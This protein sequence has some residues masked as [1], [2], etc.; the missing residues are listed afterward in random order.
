MSIDH[1]LSS[2][3]LGISP[4]EDTS[5]VPAF[6]LAAD[7]H[8]QGNQGD[9]WF[10]PTTWGTRAANGLKFASAA[11][12]SGGAQLF[13]AGV[14]LGNM[15]G[16][17]DASEVNTS[18]LMHSIDDDIGVYYDKNR[19]AEDLV[20]FIAS[21]FVPGT[22]GMKVL[23]AGQKVLE[24]AIATGRIGGN[25]AKAT[26]LLV[27]KTSNFIS[28]AAQDINAAQATFSLINANT[29][30]ALAAGAGQ[31]ALEAA[32]FE[33]AVQATMFSSPIL[34]DQD[35]WDIVKNIAVGG[36]AGGVIGGVLEGAG[37]LSKI[38]KQVKEF[39]FANKANSSRALAQEMNRSDIDLVR[40]AQDLDNATF[41]N[42][43]PEALTPE[44]ELS[45][46]VVNKANFADKQR[47][48]LNDSRQ[49]IHNITSSDDGLIGNMVADA[50][51]GMNA[52]DTAA[53]FLHTKHISRPN[54]ITPIERLQTE[55]NKAVHEGSEEAKVELT[56]IQTSYVKLTGE[57]A[58]AVTDAKPAI[59]SI[60]DTVPM[61]GF[62]SL[63]EAVQDEVRGYKFKL[64]SFWDAAAK[65]NKGAHTEAEARYIWA[66]SVKLPEESM[67]IH[68]NDIPLLER[69]WQEG[70]LDLKL[71]NN[72]GKIVQDGFTSREDLLAKIIE[73][74]ENVASDLVLKRVFRNP[75]A[76]GGET[77]TEAIAKI[78]NTKRG[79]LD[80][81]VV[82]NPLDDYFSHQ[83]AT[84]NY[85][86]AQAKKG[87]KVND[88]FDSLY[89]PS[90]AKFNKHLPYDM[91]N[92]HVI[93]GMTWIKNQEARFQEDVNKVFAARVPSEL[94]SSVGHIPEDAL[95]R[96]NKKGSGA[97]IFTFANGNYGSL[98]SIMQSI[99]SVTQKL[100]Q[101][102]RKDTSD[103]FQG[104]LTNLGKNQEAVIEFNSMN[105]K[106]TRS[107][108]LWVRIEDPSGVPHMIT[109][110]G[111]IAIEKAQQEGKDI[112]SIW[113]S[114]R[115]ADN[116]IEFQN[117]EVAEVVDKMINRSAYR[118]TSFQEI[119]AAQGLTDAK[120]PTVYRPVR[121]N[122]QDYKHFAFVVDPKVTSQ[123]HVTMIF[124]SDADK[125]AKLRAAAERE[126]FTVHYKSEVEE[127]KKARQE[128]EYA[129][130]LNESYI[131]STLA[132]RGVFSE[133]FVKTD[134]QQTINGIL[135]QHFREDD[136]LAMELM[137]MK[138][139]KAFD[140]LEDQ[141]R[142]YSRVEASTL[143]GPSLS[144]IENS[145]KNPYVDY[146]KT[147][148]DI[149]RAP[150]YS[151]WY[152]FNKMIDSQVSRAVNTIREAWAG[153]KSP[154]EL[155]Q[156]NKHLDTYGMNTGFRDAALEALV[157]HPAPKG[158]L[159][160]FIRGANA[161][162]AR[163]TLGLDPMNA[164]NNAIGANVLRGTELTQITRAI[165]NGDSEIA[166]KLAELS[167]ITL[168][169]VGDQITA[170]SK[171]LGR[172]IKAF[173][174]EP[175][176]GE[177]F[178][179]F[180]S[181]GYMKD[182]GTQFK[183]IL[184]DFTL[185]GTETAGEL[186]TRLA[187]GFGRA[188]ALVE[189]GEKYSGN[190]LAEDF[191]RFISAHVMKQLTDVAI[192]QGILS[193]T[194]QHAYIN[195]FINRV[196]GNTIASQRPMAFQGP[197]GQAIG[198]FQSYQFNMMQQ[199]FRYV[200]EGTRKD[201]AM[202][203]GLQ[204]TFYGLNGLP[205]FQTINQHIVGTM[206]G[207]KNHTDLYD[208]TYGAAGKQAGDL[209]LYGL[210]SNLLSANL[211]SRGDLTPR[212]V[213]ILPS[214]LGEIPFISAYGKFLGSLKDTATKISG[215]A[216][217]WES[218]LQGIE[219]QGIS[220]P[221]SGL[222]QTLQAF[223]DGGKVYSTTTKGSILFQNDLM[224]LATLT[225]LAGARPLEEAIVNDGMFR[226]QSYQQYNRAKMQTLAESVKTASIQGNIPSES[227]VINFAYT[228]AKNGGK[229]DQF[230]KFILNEIKSA[231]SN[232]AEKIVRQLN[233]PFVQKVQILM[234]GS[235][236][237]VN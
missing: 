141:G 133:H 88:S 194:E 55:L 34:K 115:N 190:A 69:A 45:L 114:L 14:V 179:Q 170:P 169:E 4:D 216:P 181:L 68:M 176:D 26:G 117:P 83:S 220:R 124:A 67:S 105:A 36:L 64:N 178:K 97:G 171:L 52:Q 90:T 2:P 187:K 100:K 184:D 191:N 128:Y 174:Q 175:E 193:P 116:L 212:Q 42:K 12:V 223:G 143:G 151:N 198:L 150:E 173:F 122:P 123:G 221:L 186:N 107:G 201:T 167:K 208:A 233:N 137:R 237:I 99:G 227:D 126:G 156:I 158:E 31:Q 136:V 146:I 47:R 106:I 58:G 94:A 9:S 95:W 25:L 56:R 15:T 217:V 113:D 72:R 3:S 20:G 199:L 48:I 224:S 7:A 10:D 35:S 61:R 206:S 75:E 71:V 41:V 219:H 211:Y 77:A 234:G 8:N 159:T 66:Q 51:V 226:I 91:A 82:E 148:L 209:L 37:T 172:A 17:M 162:L 200:A 102:Y 168:P 43:L 149:S 86:D 84:K 60:A 80:K 50:Q 119:R 165:K 182:A 180:K 92:G 111:K 125:L 228:Y 74:K 11:I 161:V 142:T 189:A 16:A 87:L 183:D 101:S 76:D 103:I 134:P 32:A 49:A 202:L 207:N 215:G 164:L 145:I 93:D 130:T 112:S 89:H 28:A 19:Q 79:R 63:A 23:N 195:T 152:S 21:S 155:D 38:G 127:F 5:N 1:T 109:K 218:I 144:K 39:E 118:T 157:N 163:F 214:S 70:K 78:V 196:E 129:R 24:G 53:T 213:T 154:A 147:A 205:G 57:G 138:N 235:D 22:A 85:K 54:T 27:P 29:I 210:P 230:N 104:A 231:N 110:E 98:E 131:D 33:T 153:V 192:E 132:N 13:N 18:E 73:T 236:G 229:Q 96:A 121:P 204:G 222:A 65:V 62:S 81:T 160:K 59:L 120:D 135:N 6:L 232:Q 166:G 188:K 139:Q 140:Y 225:R 30:K 40:Y 108:K 185:K 197:T 203:L 46:T 44:Q 177:L